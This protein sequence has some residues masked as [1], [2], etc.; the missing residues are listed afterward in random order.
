M[1]EKIITFASPV[2]F[3]FIAIEF[4]VGLR[5]GRNTYRINDMLNSLSLGVMS[6]IVGVFMKI[7]AIGIYAWVF[8]HFSLFKLPADSI[9]VWVSGLLLYDFL[10]YWLHRMGHETAV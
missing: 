3:L 7:L 1:Q 10:Y 5:R 9:W 6:Q 2:F 4:I 8:A